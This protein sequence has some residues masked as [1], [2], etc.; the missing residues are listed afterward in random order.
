MTMQA[1]EVFVVVI[2][3]LETGPVEQHDNCSL[4]CW[5]DLGGGSS[6]IGLKPLTLAICLAVCA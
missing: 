3:H 4:C 5:D 6:L 1:F 2:Y